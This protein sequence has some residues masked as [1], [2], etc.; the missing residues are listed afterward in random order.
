[1]D[2]P[3]RMNG[4]EELLEEFARAQ[5]RAKD[6]GAKVRSSVQTTGGQQSAGQSAVDRR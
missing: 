1:M 5:F 3:G 2:D 6:V 4:L